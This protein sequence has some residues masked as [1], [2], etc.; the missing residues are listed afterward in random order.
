[1]NPL[2]DLFVWDFEKCSNSNE[3]DLKSN[4]GLLLRTLTGHGGL[5][6]SVHATSFGLISC[7]ITGLIIE[8]DF[9]KCIEVSF[10]F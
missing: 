5:V 8:R 3:S 7:D 9:W 1:M 10:N 6:H 4:D 2:L